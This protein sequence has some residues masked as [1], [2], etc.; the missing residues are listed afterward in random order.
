[1]SQNDLTRMIA[2]NFSRE[3]SSS[4]E[5]QKIMTA[6]VVSA[7]MK[8]RRKKT[9]LRDS[10]GREFTKRRS[11]SGQKKTELT[12]EQI[13]SWYADNNRTFPVAGATAASYSTTEPSKVYVYAH[14]ATEIVLGRR[15]ILETNFGSMLDLP[16]LQRSIE[17]DAV[18]KILRNDDGLLTIGTHTAVFQ[19]TYAQST[20]RVLRDLAHQGLIRS[21]DMPAVASRHRGARDTTTT[22]ATTGEWRQSF[23]PFLWITGAHCKPHVILIA[24]HITH[25]VRF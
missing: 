18:Y 2:R 13:V 22:S 20:D 21:W 15:D 6:F 25:G 23:R 7:H 1:M 5:Q 4:A 24:N 8:A 19:R 14:S 9:T 11:N 16:E 12:V 3:F 17:F 10:R